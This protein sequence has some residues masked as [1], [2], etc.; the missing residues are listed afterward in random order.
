MS[1]MSSRSHRTSPRLCREGKFAEAGEKYWADD[2]V[3]LEP[4]EGDMARCEGR[5]AV[6]GKGEWWENAHEVHS[7]EVGDPI[8][9]GNQFLMNFK[10]DVTQKESGQRMQ[11][12][13]QALYTVRDGK[14][15]EERFFYQ[16]G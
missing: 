8:V 15:A 6:E 12:D 13:E 7:A 4:G 5:Q 2:V 10:M 14:I 9:N 3:S 16:M 11:M 1:D